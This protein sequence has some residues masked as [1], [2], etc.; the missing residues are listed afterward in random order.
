MYTKPIDLETFF[1]ACEISFMEAKNLGRRSSIAMGALAS[2]PPPETQPE[3]L[4]LC[5]LTAPLIEALEGFHEQLQERMN[6]LTSDTEKL[7]TTVEAT[8][9]PLLRY[10]ASDDPAHVNE[11]RRAGK[12]LKKECQLAAKERFAQQRLETEELVRDSLVF[13]GEI[14]T[15]SAQSI[16]N[17]RAIAAE[18]ISSANGHIIKLRAQR[19]ASSKKADAA[20][21]ASATKEQVLEALACKRAAIIAARKALEASE[22]NMERMRSRRLSIKP[23]RERLQEEL[24][25][26]REAQ[27]AAADATVS[28]KSFGGIDMEDTPSRLRRA[29]QVRLRAKAKNAQSASEELGVLSGLAPWR[30]EGVGGPAGAELTIRVGAL[31]RVT[32]DASTGAGRVTLIDGPEMTP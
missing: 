26:M 16:A 31:F 21:S 27:D 9:P 30:L 8:Q 3:A 1:Y 11:L 24:D 17:S 15:K 6:S 4:K 7:R 12:A 23:E 18:A 14:L 29:S 10:A 5:C 13:H 25:A 19:A 20:K 28:F 32:L 22:Q 2:A